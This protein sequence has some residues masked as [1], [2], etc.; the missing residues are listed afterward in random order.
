M[1]KKE[2][3][4]SNKK[5]VTIYLDPGKRAEIENYFLDLRLKN[6]QTGYR[7]IMSLGFEVFKKKKKGGKK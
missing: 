1:P 4:V 7:E 3:I 2:L 6:F 5:Q